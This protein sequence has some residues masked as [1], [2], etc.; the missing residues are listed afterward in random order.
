[1]NFQIRKHAKNHKYIIFFFVIC[2]ILFNLFGC[3]FPSSSD[4]QVSNPNDSTK[5]DKAFPVK[6]T[7]NLH[8]PENLSP[9]ENIVIEILDE[10]SGLPYNKDIYE[11]KKID[12]LLYNTE[13]S[14]HY[15]S[16]IKYRYVK[17]DVDATSEA[18]WN[19]EPVRYRLLYAVNDVVTNDHL[20]TWAGEIQTANTGRI[21]GLLLDAETK[22]PI[23][24]ILVS[25]AGQLTFSDSNGNFSLENLSP[26][27]HNLVFYALDGKYHTFQQE[28]R[29]S[30]GLVTPA[31][32]ELSPSQ[33]V[34]LTFQVKPPSDALGAPIYLAGNIRQLGNTFIDLMGSVSVRQ[35]NMPQL[36]LNEDGSY[37]VSL[38]LYSGTYLRYKFTLG[39]G[40]WNAERDAQGET[41]TREMV[42][43]TQ[44]TTVEVTIHSWR[45]STKAPITFQVQV[46]PERLA[47]QKYF[48]QFRSQKWTEPI[49]LWPIGKND[50]LYILYTPLEDVEALDYLVCCQENCF[51]D[52]SKDEATL[53]KQVQPTEDPQTVTLD[54]ESFPSQDVVATDDSVIDAYIPNRGENFQTIIELSPSIKPIA[55]EESLSNISKLA[56]IKTS[57]IAFTPQWFFTTSNSPV[58]TQKFG[59]TPLFNDLIGMLDKTKSMGFSLS[60]FPQI[61]PVDEITQFWQTTT[62][63]DSWWETWFDSYANFVLNYAKAAEL[64]GARQL[65]IG[66][67]F[68]L[69][70]FKGGTYPN[71][72]F[73]D[74]PSNSDEKW[75]N[76]ISEV[77][78]TYQGEL[79][80]ATNVHQ[81]RDPLPEFI[82]EFDGIYL[83]V[84]SPLVYSETDD[85]D[86]INWGFINVI[87]SLIYEVYRSTDL[88]ITLGLGYP[89][90]DGGAL[91][92]NLLENGCI[93]DGIFSET[94]VSNLAP[95]VQ[96]QSLIYNAIF[97]VLTSREWITGV[98]VRGYNPTHQ[99]DER[100]SSIAGKPALQVIEYWYSGL[101]DNNQ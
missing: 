97:P 20:Q 50:L 63:V 9:E 92:C 58:L 77:R 74:V 64:S 96:E 6:V 88:P 23:P 60:L 45:S 36:A 56:E 46:Q 66:G 75:Q 42:V 71:G 21:T 73:S 7:F 54:L 18:T 25:V 27:T 3:S 10:V 47:N 98:A 93:N 33:T 62:H 53:V 16:V 14:F 13:L 2:T 91:G 86:S 17:S 19:G 89:S 65:I 70:T 24:D 55:L 38:D 8:L 90:V 5:N 85:F 4:S 69:P 82:Y 68:L 39:D 26:Q 43:P 79:L 83:L 40:Y 67:K 28:A 99:L 59:A 37:N 84:D 15:G 72:A 49:P 22:S 57:T 12:S 35:E 52:E 11:L 95:D 81:A 30:P 101:R 1:M 32:V 80:W 87:D 48:I 76:L 51:T 78:K 31:N 29:I 41:I 100:S 94:E 44:D 34:K 61:G